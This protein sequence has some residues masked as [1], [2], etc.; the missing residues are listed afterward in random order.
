M[1]VRCEKNT[2]E[3]KN[4]TDQNVGGLTLNPKLL[5]AFSGLPFPFLIKPYLIPG[6]KGTGVPD[7][8]SSF[9][10]GV[11]AGTSALEGALLKE[12][13][14]KRKGS[15]RGQ[16]IRFPFKRLQKRM[17]ASSGA[18]IRR[19]EQRPKSPLSNRREEWPA[20]TIT[21]VPWQG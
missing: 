12:Q 16:D 17:P 10:N 13:T 14:R 7:I 6:G 1:A 19:V 15:E 4:K 5:F 2:P 20:R 18:G 3:T 21:P 8:F 11:K 9:S